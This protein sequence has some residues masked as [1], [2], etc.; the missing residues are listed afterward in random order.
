MSITTDDKQQCTTRRLTRPLAHLSDRTSLTFTRKHTQL[1]LGIRPDPRAKLRNNISV[2]IGYIELSNVADIAANVY[3]SLPIPY[4]IKAVMFLGG[5]V[6]TGM[7]CVIIRDAFLSWQNLRGLAAER[8][9]LLASLASL[10]CPESG[11]DTALKRTL[12]CFLQ[13][14]RQ[15]AQAELI[16]RF[17]MEC[18]VAIG[19]LLVGVGTYMAMFGEDPYLFETSNLLTGY[20]GNSPFALCGVVNLVW[21]FATLSHLKHRHHRHTS[22]G[23]VRDHRIQAMLRNRARYIRLHGIL[24]GGPG[25]VSG[26]MSLATATQWW[27]Y[28]ILFPCI[29]TSVIANWLWRKKIGYDRPFFHQ[30]NTTAG[31]V[32]PTTEDEIIRALEE[33]DD[34]RRQVATMRLVSKTIGFRPL[35]EFILHI[36][37]FE[38]FCLRLARDG[39]LR[40]TFL[41]LK[42][43]TERVTLDVY[44]L[45]DPALNDD[46]KER[47]LKVARKTVSEEAER[48]LEHRERWLLEVLGCYMALG[49]QDKDVEKDD[50]SDNTRN[51]STDCLLPWR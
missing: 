12:K 22:A 18:V 6:C 11:H 50:P 29:F 33:V 14:N 37:L 13:I 27:A 45:F 39:V 23:R 25:I 47:L 49:E 19:S 48:G 36:N 8:K 40:E 7:L 44:G 15:D 34:C 31:T 35:L 51:G 43:K 46:I 3:N 10:Q 30:N 4:I 28:V 21:A 42:E 16:Y 17:G 20:L 26:A 41:P 5:T 38:E 24:N 2:A 9:S 1:S 32:A